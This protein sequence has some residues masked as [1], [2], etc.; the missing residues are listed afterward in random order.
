MKR[1]FRRDG[2]THVEDEVIGEEIDR[3]RRQQDGAAPAGW[4][5]A[6]ALRCGDLRGARVGD[7]GE[8]ADA[9][10]GEEEGKEAAADG[11]AM[12]MCMR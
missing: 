3:W 4:G 8:D 1:G 11:R 6:G 12:R 2:E 10:R 9:A 5:G 7:S